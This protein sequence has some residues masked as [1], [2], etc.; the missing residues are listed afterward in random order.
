MSSSALEIEAAVRVLVQA[1]AV[2]SLPQESGSLSLERAA[3]RLDVGA[4]WIRAHLAEFPGWYRLPAG[5]ARGRN[6]GELR[7]PMKDLER[8]EE[9]RRK[10]RVTV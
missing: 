9:N 2:F 1:G 6:V 10:A 3:A 5:T 8:F 7:I 4:N